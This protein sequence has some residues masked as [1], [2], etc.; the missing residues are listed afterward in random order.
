MHADDTDPTADD[1]VIETARAIRPYLDEL[2]GPRAAAG[3]DRQLA[4]ALLAPVSPADRV[5]RLRDLIDAHLATRDFLTE[6]LTDPPLFRPPDQ[7]PGYE[8]RTPN[9]RPL[10]DPAPVSA[11]RYTC[12]HGDYVWYRP[13][14][15]TPVRDCPTHQVRLVRS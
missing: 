13:D 2:V 10:G 3:L 7:Q 14:V 6:I 4:D 12:R 1:G 11:D 15:G 9:N 5:R 8:R